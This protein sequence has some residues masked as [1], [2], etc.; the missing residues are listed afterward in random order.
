MKTIE[1]R[2][3]KSFT[4][5]RE[6][7]SLQKKIFGVSEIDTFP[8]LILYVFARESPP[9]GIVI[10]AFDKSPREEKLVGVF[11]GTAML[12]ENAYY[13]LVGGVLP[14]YQ[15][16]NIGTELFR[17]LREIALSRNVQYFYWSYEPLEGNLAHTNY[18][19]LGHL[20]IKYDESAYELTDD[21]PPDKN[22]P[23]D[24][25]LIK[26]E[27]DSQRVREKKAGT[28]RGK[29]EI[30]KALSKYPVIDENNFTDSNMV[31]VEIP[32]NF[33]ALKKTSFEKALYWRLSTRK[34]FN[35]YIN[36]RGY[37]IT[38]FYSQKKEGERHNYY[39]LEKQ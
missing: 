27:L 1:Y 24:K 22:I 18:N 9:V 5:F 14:E 4:E 23:I 12:R 6:C 35:E 8:P 15:G 38:E 10:G 20:G 29:I 30:E 33:I 17:K 2:E 32:E 31:L 25:I 21:A 16:Q 11:F 34:I 26:W 36:K 39:L 3:L 13:G 28:Y 37:W 19:K 7:I